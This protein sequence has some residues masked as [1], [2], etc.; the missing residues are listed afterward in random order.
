[1]N[2][3]FSQILMQSISTSVENAH[4]IE[5]AFG[6][7]G[8]CCCWFP[9]IHQSILRSF[10]DLKLKLKLIWNRL[11]Y[12]RCTLCTV[13]WFQFQL[14][15]SSFCAVFSDELRECRFASKI[16]ELGIFKLSANWKHVHHLNELNFHFEHLNK[17]HRQL[18]YYMHAH[19]HT[20]S[21]V[22]F[23]DLCEFCA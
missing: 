8:L 5:T 6:C 15:F 7:C 22:S 19:M 17:S 21:I 10:V 20:Y 3:G 12:D 16:V 23:V 9:S 11:I 13:S 4:C 18:T 2:I 14:Y 1:M